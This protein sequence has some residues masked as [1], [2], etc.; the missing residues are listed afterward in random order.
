M[1]PRCVGVHDAVKSP[2]AQNSDSEAARE[3][4]ALIRKRLAARL[5][6]LGKASSYAWIGDRVGEDRRQVRKWVTGSSDTFPAAFAAQLEEAGIVSARYL[7]TG[8]GPA[9]PHEP[10]TA[11]LRLSVI[12]LVAD[13]KLDDAVVRDLA[14]RLNRPPIPPT[15]TLETEADTDPKEDDEELPNAG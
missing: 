4:N 5:E 14:A 13:G 7:L 3:R 12:G 15:S 11:T 8:V 2:M 6:K 9:E 1:T 10:E